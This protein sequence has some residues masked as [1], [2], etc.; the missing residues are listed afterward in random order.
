MKGKHCLI[1]KQLLCFQYSFPWK[2]FP[3]HLQLCKVYLKIPLEYVRSEVHLE[4]AP[5]KTFHRNI[6]AE[7]FLYMF[8]SMT[9]HVGQSYLGASCYFS[10]MSF[11]R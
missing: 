10:A 3:F 7:L 1:S 4:N 8:V 9:S 11:V 6:S 2:T 5:V